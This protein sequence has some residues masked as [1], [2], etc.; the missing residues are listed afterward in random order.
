[1][2]KTLRIVLTALIVAATSGCYRQSIRAVD[3]E[4]NLLTDRAGGRDSDTSFGLLYGIVPGKTEVACP[5]GIARVD[6]GLAWYSYFVIY[7]TAAIVVP[8][9]A[10][11]TCNEAPPE[12][13]AGPDNGG[14]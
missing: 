14:W 10:T 12:G 5:Y 2:Q 1:M 6:T 13:S 9:K 8:M 7:L 4:G 11:Y 3:A